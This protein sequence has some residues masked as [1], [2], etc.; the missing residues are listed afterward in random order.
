MASYEPD[1]LKIAKFFAEIYG[2]DTIKVIPLNQK[3]LIEGSLISDFCYRSQLSISELIDFDIKANKSLNPYLCEILARIS[4]I[5]QDVHDNSPK[6]ILTNYVNTQEILLAN[7]KK[8]LDKQQRNDILNCFKRDNQI[9]SEEYFDDL[10]YDEF[11][12]PNPYMTNDEFA[13]DLE[14]DIERLKDI[15]AIQMEIILKLLK[16]QEQKDKEIKNQ[17]KLTKII[18]RIDRFL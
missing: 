8:I 10:S 1:F 6:T 16:K 13:K 4:H 18:K 7:N 11:V 3:A 2:K 14:Y 9:L 5:Y 15:V 12:N 17:G